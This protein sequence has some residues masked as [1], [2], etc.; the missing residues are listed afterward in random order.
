MGLAFNTSSY[1]GILQ[2]LEPVCAS[3]DKPGYYLHRRAPEAGPTATHKPAEAIL[4]TSYRTTSH[5]FA[6]LPHRLTERPHHVSRGSRALPCV[7]HAGHPFISPLH[8]HM[9]APIASVSSVRRLILLL[10]P[11]AKLGAGR[12]QAP[13]STRYPRAASSLQPALPPGTFQP[14]QSLHT[15]KSRGP[16]GSPKESTRETSLQI[17]N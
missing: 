9:V 12:R 7:S 6:H 5:L 10:P 1:Q 4:S 8:R 2:Q 17:A 15:Y 13:G 3:L 14:Q 16:A 11:P